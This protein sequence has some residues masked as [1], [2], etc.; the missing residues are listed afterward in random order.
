MK[1]IALSFIFLFCTLL[2]PRIFAQNKPVAIERSNEKV[3]ISGNQFYI[4]VVKSGQT[5]FSI[6][7][8]YNVTEK[9]ITDR[10]T[11]VANGLKEGR[12]VM[13]PVIKGR[14]STEEEIIDNGN[15]I[16]HT[17]EKGQT[18]YYISK[19]YQVEIEDL[20]KL[21]PGIEKGLKTGQVLKIKP[22]NAN[23]AGE[24]KNEKTDNKEKGR[25][26]ENS[27]SDSKQTGKTVK[28]NT[29]NQ[30]NSI[31]GDSDMIMHEVRKKE[32][33]IAISKKYNIDLIEIIKVNPGIDNRDLKKGEI[34]LVPKK[35]AE[36][37]PDRK[38]QVIQEEEILPKDIPCTKF[39]YSKTPVTFKIALLMPLYL[40]DFEKIADTDTIKMQDDSKSEA[41]EIIEKS[42]VFVEFYDG[43]LLALDSLKKAGISFD[44]YV[45]DTEKDSNLVK[46]IILKPEL[47]NMDMIIGPVFST[48]FNIVSGFAKENNINIVTPLSSRNLALLSNSRL[49]QVIP[50]QREQLRILISSL[51]AYKNERIVILHGGK[52]TE[53][54][55][56]LDFKKE[57][58]ELAGTAITTESYREVTVNIDKNIQMG[59]ESNRKIMTLIKKNLSSVSSN[60]VFIPSSDAALVAELVNQLNNIISEGKNIYD[61]TVCGFPGWQ[62]YDNLETEYLH[63][64]Q[65]ITVS[66]NYIDY[67]IPV[68][69]KF[70]LNYRSTFSTEPSQYSYQG[71]DVGMFFF[72][73]LKDYGMNFGQCI[74]ESGL[75]FK[76]LQTDFHFRRSSKSGGFENHYVSVIQYT[77]DLNIIRLNKDE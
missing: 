29:G 17:V 13:I 40:R 59:D 47:K 56:V 36:N 27:G 20:Q 49:F 3:L 54:D 28:P 35:Q 71:Y 60:L 41:A 48:N 6:A 66:S 65:L 50:S 58:S 64:L 69:K 16:F 8:A 73:A 53:K 68:I 30:I 45:Y 2:L 4:H 19:K 72:S 32:T 23:A 37:V 22:E 44:V 26:K 62:K 34:I 43:I 51:Q 57:F 25:T 39:S 12:S 55:I 15:Y 14:N 77:K 61:I 5:L 21:N 70:I 10:N 75:T 31:S 7:R 52:K 9:D 63:N 76:G 33:L 67:S 74:Q 46:K 18:L 42:R 24:L 38:A 11:D 1:R